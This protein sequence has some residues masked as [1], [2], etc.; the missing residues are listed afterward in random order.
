[1][2]F[3]NFWIF[4]S[5]KGELISSKAQR[6]RKKVTAHLHFAHPESSAE[7]EPL[8]E[9]CEP[10]RGVHVQTDRAHRIAQGACRLLVQR[11]R[12]AGLAGGGG[13]AATFGRRERGK[14]C[15]EG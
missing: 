6:I 11:G 5:F 9:V 8:G 2:S 10:F 3:T 12:G 15:S 4:A 7:D 1:M 13:T 14:E